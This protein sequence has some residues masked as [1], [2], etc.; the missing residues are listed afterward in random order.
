MRA[1]PLCIDCDGTLI[2]T[3]LLHEG[4]L[5]LVKQAPLCAAA[6]AVL[7]AARQGLLQAARRRARRLPLGEPA[8]SPAGARA[9]AARRAPKRGRCCSP[10]PRPGPGPTAS[11]RTSAAS[12]R[13]SRPRT[14]QP[15]RA[16]P[17]RR[18]SPSCTA[19]AASTT[20]ATTATTSP[21][22]PERAR[23]SSSLSSPAL[24]ARAR[25]V[26]RGPGSGARRARRPLAYLKMI[27][28]H[29]WMKNLLIFLPMVAAHRIG[30]A[31]SL[32]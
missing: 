4:L 30:S 10:P 25:A 9:D 11:P 26:V 15:A 21:S 16:R 23:R 24:V 20:P 5:L 13:W 19:R 31:D 17:R 27:R 18:G 7:A 12:P 32:L 8:V 28:V 14:A 2:R 6:A 29:Q 22:G 3:D 1:V